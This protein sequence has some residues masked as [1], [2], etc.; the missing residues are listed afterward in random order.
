[1]PLA[2]LKDAFEVRCSH[3]VIGTQQNLPGA[4]PS[5]EAIEIHWCVYY[6]ATHVTQLRLGT[7]MAMR[8]GGV[9]GSIHVTET[10][11]RQTGASSYCQDRWPT[12]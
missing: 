4:T 5:F 7:G 6:V 11:R 8:D 9:G 3:I 10:C 2:A 1:M 12:P